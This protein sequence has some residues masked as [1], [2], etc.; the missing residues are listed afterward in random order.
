[1]GRHSCTP[2][3]SIL[4][5]SKKDSLL[6]VLMGFLGYQGLGWLPLQFDDGCFFFFLR[7]SGHNH[8]RKH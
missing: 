6:L 8:T 2:V 3:K 4:T 5:S 1:M 7:E